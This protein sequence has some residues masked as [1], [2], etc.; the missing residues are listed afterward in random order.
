[1]SEG[2]DLICVDSR[3]FG[4]KVCR[5]WQPQT[6]ECLAEKGVSDTFVAKKKLFHFYFVGERGKD[7]KW[8]EYKV[9]R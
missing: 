5:S 8:C 7:L 6:G 2:V 4:N 1:M 9:L 3:G